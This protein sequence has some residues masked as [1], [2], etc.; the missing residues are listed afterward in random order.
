MLFVCTDCVN[1]EVKSLCILPMNKNKKVQ[2]SD[3][4]YFYPTCQKIKYLFL[5]D[6]SLCHVGRNGGLMIKV[7]I[8]GSSGLCSSPVQEHCVVFLDK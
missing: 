1:L 3:H 4:H 6:Y 7:L 2:S 5:A 8:P